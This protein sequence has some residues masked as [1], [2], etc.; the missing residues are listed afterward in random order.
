ME[1]YRYH[2]NFEHVVQNIVYNNNKQ[3]VMDVEL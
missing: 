3:S 2:M 1:R